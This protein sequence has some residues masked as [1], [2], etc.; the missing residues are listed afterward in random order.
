MASVGDAT[1]TIQT[2]LSS[3]LARLKIYDY[4]LDVNYAKS[5][6]DNYGSEIWRV[7]VKHQ[8]GEINVFVKI[9]INDEQHRNLVNSEKTFKNEATF[10]TTVFPTLDQLQREKQVNQPFLIP[11]CYAT[12]L[13]EGEEALAL[14]D[15][16][17]AGF[18]MCDRKKPL[19]EAQIALVLKQ[20]GKLHAL[21]SALRDQ[22]PQ[23]FKGI[24]SS[25]TDLSALFFHNLADCFKMQALINAEMLERFSLT[26]ESEVARN[27]AEKLEEIL[28]IPCEPDDPYAVLIHGDCW[29]NNMMFK[30]DVRICRLF[31]FKTRH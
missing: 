8:S 2:L 30:Y 14:E 4:T 17:A 1:S 12:S 20:Y 26:A 10:Y 23:I 27:V 7:K 22:N 3:S 6:G 21:S 25:V 24:S 28:T 5:K 31:T 11:K 15:L 13:K 29:C 9:A 18:E 16:K 19:D